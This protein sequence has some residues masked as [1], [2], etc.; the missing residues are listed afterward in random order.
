[1]M[2]VLVKP[3]FDAEHVAFIRMKTNIAASHQPNAKP[4]SALLTRAST[5]VKDATS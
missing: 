2:S 5:V 4:T 3:G 1:M